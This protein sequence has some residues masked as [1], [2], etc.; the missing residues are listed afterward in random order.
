MVDWRG[1]IPPPAVT[2]GALG[3]GETPDGDERPWTQA[4][5]Q[6]RRAAR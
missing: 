5:A 2:P 1:V 3:N 6:A 4:P